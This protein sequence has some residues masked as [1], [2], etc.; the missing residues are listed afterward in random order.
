MKNKS[1]Y[2]YLSNKHFFINLL[3]EFFI[4]FIRQVIYLNL[5]S[6]Y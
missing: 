5:S 6:F 3:K 4:F 1:N 2:F